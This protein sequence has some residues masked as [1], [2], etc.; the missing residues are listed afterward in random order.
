MVDELTSYDPPK[1]NKY[2]LT[3]LLQNNL[4]DITEVKKIIEGAGYTSESPLAKVC[5]PETAVGY[6]CLTYSTFEFS[7]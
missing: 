5:Y 4:W 1:N 6:G 2:A 3:E 7:Y